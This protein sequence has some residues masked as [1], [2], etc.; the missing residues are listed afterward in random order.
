MPL[1]TL[2]KVGSIT[3]LT[4]ARYCAGMEVDMLGFRV[5]AGQENYIPPSQ[6]QEIRGWITG[7]LIVAEIYGL[8]SAAD[9]EV[10]LENYKPNYLE[11]GLKELTQFDQLSLPVLLTINAAEDISGI[12]IK[13]AYVISKSL[14]K[15]S[16]PLL[17]EVSA[18]DV[19][20]SLLENDSVSGLVLK[21]SNEQRPGLKE[22][23]IMNDV[24]ELLES[25][26]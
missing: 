22:F 16:I 12:A 8:T 18:T 4:D 6:F 1:K 17:I 13:P 23:G 3:N 2:V 24:L 9:L 20:P 26:N 10:I 7:P 14:L 5:V 19:V 11:M 25:D 15:S 21:G